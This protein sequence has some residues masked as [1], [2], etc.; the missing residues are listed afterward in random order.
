MQ[1][2]KT[3]RIALWYVAFCALALAVSQRQRLGWCTDWRFAAMREFARDES[4]APD[5]LFF[6]SSYT[7]RGLR[8]KIFE[9]EF[10]SSNAALRSALNL[11]NN[12]VPQHVNSLVLEDWLAHHPAPKVVC[13]E[14]GQSNLINW[15][16]VLL[17]NL[18]GPRDAVRLA[19]RAPY[20]VE[21]PKRYWAMVERN[22]AG[23]AFDFSTQVSRRAWHF[24]LAL[25]ILG[26]GPED[27]VRTG[28]NGLANA[29]E[30]RGSG[31][32]AKQLFNPYWS[33]NP[34]IDDSTIQDQVAQG[35]W[36]RVDPTTP[37]YAEG[38]AKVLAR[39]AAISIA[40]ANAIVCEH[41]YAGERA[42][43]ANQLYV[44]RIAAMCKR[45]GV[46]LVF[47]YMPAFRDKLGRPSPEHVAFMQALGEVYMPD[48]DTLQE[49]ENYADEGHLSDLGG[50]RYSRALAKY[51]AR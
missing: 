9:E 24:D 32:V 23:K 8:P 41:A 22:K 27:V 18:S 42:H 12:G 33:K 30:A 26:R 13:V 29:F 5:V 45:H 14:F 50:E 37:T 6:G 3:T 10:A 28:F 43:A 48:M 16:H 49:E 51:L 47:H 44:E 38:R 36:Y 17:S 25:E 31:Q 15:P 19:W 21:T 7:E 4:R 11:A 20:F 46:R 1:T 35:G 34:P 2:S 39:A 40:D